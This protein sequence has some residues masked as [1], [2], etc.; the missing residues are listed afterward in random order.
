MDIVDAAGL[1]PEDF[2][3]DSYSLFATALS[4]VPVAA[5]ERRIRAAQR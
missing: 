5:R 1:Q 2:L 3:R 4:K